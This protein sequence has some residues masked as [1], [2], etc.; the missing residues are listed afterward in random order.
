M[1]N[2]HQDSAEESRLVLDDYYKQLEEY[3][4]ENI[5]SRTELN[6]AIQTVEKNIPTDS[7]GLE[8]MKARI[9]KMK[10]EHMALFRKKMEQ[11]ISNNYIKL[12][13]L[14]RLTEKIPEKKPFK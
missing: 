1:V 10:I 4:K 14:T 11:E 3:V 12:N 8:K 2:L 5:I 13:I 9:N 6:K 7:K